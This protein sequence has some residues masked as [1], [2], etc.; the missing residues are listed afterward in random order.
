MDI[1]IVNNLGIK[2]EREYDDINSESK[3]EELNW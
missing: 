1:N 3:E 2:R